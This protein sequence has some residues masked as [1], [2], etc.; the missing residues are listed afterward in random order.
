MPEKETLEY[1]QNELT[2]QI[3]G[4]DDS[5]KFYRTTHFNLTMATAVLSALTTVLIGAGRIATTNW[6]FIVPLLASASITVA[7]SYEGFLRPK[8]LWMQKT[9]T[10]MA[11]QNLDANITYA[12]KKS[13]GLSQQEIDE[14]YKRFDQ[15]LMGEHLLWMTLRAARDQAGQHER[16]L[17]RSA[18]GAST[19]RKS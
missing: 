2:R 16:G 3:A 12:V 13:G 4:F 7:S 15:I 11:L 1:L 18:T 14:F 6:W 19:A 17:S 10:W 9:D 5:R 8:E